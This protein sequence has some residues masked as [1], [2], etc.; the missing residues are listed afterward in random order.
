M[1]HSNGCDIGQSG[2]VFMW[3]T[4]MDDIL[5]AILVNWVGDLSGLLKWV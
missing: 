1:T 5:S 4:Q 3:P 2:G